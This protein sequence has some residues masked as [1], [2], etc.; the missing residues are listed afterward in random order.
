MSYCYFSLVS[1]ILIRQI[2]Q[3]GLKL[4]GIWAWEYTVHDAKK[5][6]T[7]TLLEIVNLTNLYA[8]IW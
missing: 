6:D 4:D 8:G 1:L 5:V 2:E 7:I 3:R